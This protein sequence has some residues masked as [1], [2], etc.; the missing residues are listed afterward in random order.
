MADPQPHEGLDLKEREIEEV[1][2]R[3]AIGAHI[4][5]EAIRIEGEDELKRPSSALAWSGLAAGLSMG[6]SL[7]GEGLLRSRLPDA[8]WR[9]LITKLGYSIGFLVVIL[10]RQ[11]LFT[12][13]TL[14]PVL[15][16]LYRRNRQVLANVLRLWAVILFSNLLGAAIFAWAVGNTDVFSPQVR[17]TF[18]DI[19][20]EAQNVSFGTAVLRGIF[21]GWLI[22]LVVWLMPYAEHARL[23]VIVILT[24]LVGLGGLTHIIAGSVEV[25]FLVMTGQAS[26]GDYLGG[27]M[28]PT[29]IGNTLGGVSLVAALNHAQVV[30]G[31]NQPRV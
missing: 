11:Q 10:G 15:P 14:T 20:R 29:L 3:S 30:A 16:L 9:P 24:W 6:F 28:M 7:V 18:L 19:G 4:V 2:R 8:P 23:F 25:F 13:N 5:H 21:A 22:A 31:R 1:E 17:Q 26:L 27:Y 12:E